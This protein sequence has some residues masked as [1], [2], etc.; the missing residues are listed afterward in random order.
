[1]TNKNLL[2]HI[3]VIT[4]TQSGAYGAVGKKGFILDR[5]QACYLIYKEDFMSNGLTNTY[6]FNDDV[7]YFL[8]IGTN[9]IWCLGQSRF[10][11]FHPWK[12]P[13]VKAMTLK[14]IEEELGYHVHIIETKCQTKGD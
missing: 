1:M 14:D 2:S 6:T 13:I 7:V 11:T 4:D 3:V 8:E 9:K 12:S 5:E 10:V